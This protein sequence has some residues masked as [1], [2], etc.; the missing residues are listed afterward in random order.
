[1]AAFALNSAGV[2]ALIAAGADVQN[3][4]IN[5]HRPLHH[6]VLSR[7]YS[8]DNDAAQLATIKALLAGGALAN[9]K[10]KFGK[11]ALDIAISAKLSPEVIAALR[12]ANR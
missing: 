7:P 3:P 11:S 6:A 5:K 2:R 9:A 10:D 8:K 4:D 12:T 1:M